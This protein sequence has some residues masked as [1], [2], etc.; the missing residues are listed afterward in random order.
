MFIL[1]GSRITQLNM[2]FLFKDYLE[3]VV[4]KKL[5]TGEALK[6]QQKLFFCKRHLH[7]PRKRKMTIS[8]ETLTNR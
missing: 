3:P 8:L 1:K 5:D 6:T 7:S 2:P 4:F